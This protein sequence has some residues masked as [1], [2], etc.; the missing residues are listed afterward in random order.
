MGRSNL[1][2]WEAV[3]Q[4]MRR[5]DLKIWEGLTL[6]KGRTDPL[7]PKKMRRTDSKNEKDWLKSEKV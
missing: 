1:K 5:P 2:K 6:K 4:K 7:P 3:T